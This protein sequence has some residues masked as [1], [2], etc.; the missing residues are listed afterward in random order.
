MRSG[1]WV[2]F[3]NMV[4]DTAPAQPHFSA[5]NALRSA[6]WTATAGA[7][8]CWAFQMTVQSDGG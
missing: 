8:Q 1:S 2:R 3:L 6:L 4:L 5:A 7:E